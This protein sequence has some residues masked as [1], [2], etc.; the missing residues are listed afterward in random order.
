MAKDKM[1]K[2][3]SAATVNTNA[4]SV[5]YEWEYARPIDNRTKWEKVKQAIWNPQTHQFLGRTWKSWGKSVSATK[6]TLHYVKQ[7]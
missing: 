1:P 2:T 6:V 7:V 5:K 3:P 4:N